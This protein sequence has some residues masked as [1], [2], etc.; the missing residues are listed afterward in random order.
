MKD[1][2]LPMFWAGKSFTM[3]KGITGTEL[4]PTEGAPPSSATK[5]GELSGRTLPPM[6]E[7]W[8]LNCAEPLFKE[9]SST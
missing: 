1:N 3:I 2:I 9:E 6:A 5:A 7:R 8:E 4:Q